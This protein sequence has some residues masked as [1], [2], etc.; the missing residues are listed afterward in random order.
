MLDINVKPKHFRELKKC[1]IYYTLYIIRCMVDGMNSMNT[2]NSMNSMNQFM[3][4]LIA[5]SA[6]CDK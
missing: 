3:T 2:L 4:N 6:V 5:H 1:I